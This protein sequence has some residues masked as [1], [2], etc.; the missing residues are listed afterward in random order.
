MSDRGPEL[1]DLVGEL[2]PAEGDRLRAAHALLVAAGPPPELS[3]RLAA[4]P[5][6]LPVSQPRR[7]RWSTLALAAALALGVFALGVAVG[8]RAD[9]AGTFDVVSM[10]GTASAPDASASLE[11]FD[12][13]TAGNWPMELRV[14][15]LAP[16]DGGQPYELW[17]TRDGMPHALC[18]S[19]F[20]EADGETTVPMNAPYKLLD[21][22]SWVI[23]ERGSEDVLLTT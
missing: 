5:A 19:F 20:V 12:A 15:G 4:P 8:N 9:D 1:H 22:D 6:V 14:E 13:D 2:E 17:L 23:V 10:T 3:A 7:S 16:S 21:F 18:G 11:L